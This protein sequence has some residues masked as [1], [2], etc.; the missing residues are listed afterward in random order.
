MSARADRIV[1]TVLGLDTLA[2]LPRTGW[3]LRGVRPCESIADHSYGVALVVMLLVDALREEGVS[4]D[5]ERALRMALVHD[6]PEARTGDVPMPSKTVALDAALH[7][8][9]ASLVERLL[10]PAQREDWRVMEEGQSL[11]ARIVKAADKIQMM[12]KA[13]SYGHQQRGHLVEFWAHPKN[14]DDRGIAVA[15]EVFEAICARAGKEI[16]R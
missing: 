12:I 5:G 7:E 9:E 10:P 11:E 3:L 6:A 4:V 15:R 8:L 14:F 13:L 2:D 1:D 16:P